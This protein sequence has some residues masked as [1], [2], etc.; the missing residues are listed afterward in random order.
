MH[1][2]PPGDKPTFQDVGE[3]EFKV[4]IVRT[5]VFQL[6]P[7]FMII[8]F[9]LVG[10]FFS[11]LASM[12]VIWN[13]AK[14]EAPLLGASISLIFAL[15]AF[16]NTAPQGPPI[17]AFGLV[18]VVSFPLQATYL[19]CYAGC[20]LDVVSFYWAMLFVIIGV[21]GLLLRYMM[22]APPPP[23][24]GDIQHLFLSKASAANRRLRGIEDDIADDVPMKDM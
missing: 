23:T 15:P 16:R 21:I 18:F 13:R 6:Y 19:S 8:A 10:I 7:V 20:T 4:H 24:G 22:Q 3:T 11:L 14:V 5:S 9:W 17:G 12:I 2:P 1:P